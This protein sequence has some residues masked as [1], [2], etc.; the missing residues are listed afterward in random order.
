MNKNRSVYISIGNEETPNKI[1]IGGKEIDITGATYFALELKPMESPRY[2]LSKGV[3]IKT[4]IS[5]P[6]IET[7]EGKRE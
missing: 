1:V 2:V 3:E 6:E 5:F 4:D 7:N